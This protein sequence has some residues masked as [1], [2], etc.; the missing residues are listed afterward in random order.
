MSQGIGCNRE[1]SKSA[2]S[3]LKSFHDF[4]FIVVLCV[5]RSVLDRTFPATLLL[6]TKNA[7]ILDGL[8]I[9]SSLKDLAHTMLIKAQDY[10]NDWYA[11]AL[12]LAEQVNV[13]ESKRRTC[14]RQVH[15]PNN[16]YI[17][18]SDYYYKTLTLELLAHL[19]SQL[20][21]RFDSSLIS[22]QGLSIMPSKLI[23]SFYSSTNIWRDF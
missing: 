6:Q 21:V 19:K 23:S 9:I 7:D 8:N 20:P 18:I 16:L 13:L 3:F 17:S 5:T 15:R 14:N 1:T 2:L 4:H 22:Y 10:H 12:K 11:R